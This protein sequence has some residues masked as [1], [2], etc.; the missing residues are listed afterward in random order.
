MLG[1]VSIGLL[2]EEL[3]KFVR[4][5]V[6][7]RTDGHTAVKNVRLCFSIEEKKCVFDHPVF[8]SLTKII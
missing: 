8:R 3:S 2:S 4:F 1:Q 6:D 7:V 5:F